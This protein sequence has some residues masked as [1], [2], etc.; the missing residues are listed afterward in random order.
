[1]ATM[2]LPLGLDHMTTKH[3]QSMALEEKIFTVADSDLYI[4]CTLPATAA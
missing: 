2:C 3:G 4:P 1:M